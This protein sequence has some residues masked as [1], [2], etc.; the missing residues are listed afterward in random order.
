[1]ARDRGRA[2]APRSP[3]GAPQLILPDARIRYL[4][5]AVAHETLYAEHVAWER[6][7]GVGSGGEWCGRRAGEGN[8]VEGV[9]CGGRVSDTVVGQREGG[10]YSSKRIA[11]ALLC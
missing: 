6:E 4:V 7:R 2:P 8:M 3:R 1:M 10:G 5:R 11:S 9:K